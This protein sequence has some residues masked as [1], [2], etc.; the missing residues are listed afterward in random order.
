MIWNS[1]HWQSDNQ[2]RLDKKEADNLIKNIKSNTK[3]VRKKQILALPDSGKTVNCINRS[4]VGK[5]ERY[6]VSA[7]SSIYVAP[8]E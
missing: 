2:L 1:S 5:R 6:I 3:E 7:G 4:C 8:A